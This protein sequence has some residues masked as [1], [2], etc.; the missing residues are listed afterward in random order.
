MFWLSTK[1]KTGLTHPFQV[2]GL[3]VPLEKWPQNFNTLTKLGAFFEDS[4]QELPF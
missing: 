3:L 4:L 1:K 2:S